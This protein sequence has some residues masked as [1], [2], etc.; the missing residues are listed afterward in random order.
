MRYDFGFRGHDLPVQDDI[1]GIAAAA[2]K[3]G[4]HT[5]QFALPLSLPTLTDHGNKISEGLGNY[6]R[7]VFADHG[8]AVGI[9]SCYVN[10]IDPDQQARKAALDRLKTYLGMA[11]AFGTRLVATETGSVVAGF[12]YTEKNFTQQPLDDLVESVKTVLPAANAAGT[13]LA[14]EPGANHPLYTLDRTAEL[15]AHFA[16]E[17]NLKLIID[18]ANLLLPGQHDEEGILKEAFERFGERIVAVHIKDYQWT[19]DAPRLI[20]T[21]VPGQG[22]QDIQPLIDIAEHYQPFGIKCLDELEPAHIDE[23]LATPVVQQ[24]Q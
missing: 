23:A 16:D 12:P 9:L 1:A 7:R 13:Y 8:V 2:Q 21:V 20:K 3:R 15:L 18:P 19:P 17:P 6:V 14:L 22:V 24:Y 11:P 4:I 5:L 10:M